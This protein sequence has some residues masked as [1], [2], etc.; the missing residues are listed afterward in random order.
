MNRYLEE[1][2]STEL[3]SFIQEKDLLLGLLSEIL[4][5]TGRRISE[6]LALKKRQIKEIS[7][8]EVQLTFY[9]LKK[10]RKT[11]GG[12]PL[13]TPILVILPK[14]RLMQWEEKLKS[15]KSPTKRLYFF[16]R[17]ERDPESP[18][19]MRQ[20]FS[21]FLRR[22]EEEN[23]L[24]QEVKEKE[25]LL[26]HIW[27]HSYAWRLKNEKGESIDGLKKALGHESLETTIK[28][29]GDWY[30]DPRRRFIDI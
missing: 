3:L 9:A 28:Y 20:R 2:E 30:F 7:P 24:V 14:E 21:R 6:V 23:F 5:S 1:K 12:K 25:G 8:T 22:Y 13:L 16:S 18:D 27:R 10:R 19:T 29:Y 11:K 26:F 4:Y 15:L 17:K